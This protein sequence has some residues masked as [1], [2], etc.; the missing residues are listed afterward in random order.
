MKH[1]LSDG[2]AP[3]DVPTLSTV[4]MILVNPMLN[5]NGKQLCLVAKRISWISK[6]DW[7]LL[8][9]FQP[10]PSRSQR[11][12]THT[13]ILLHPHKP[14]V[15]YMASPTA[16]SRDWYYWNNSDSLM[17]EHFAWKCFQ[18]LQ[19]WGQ[20]EQA[21]SPF[22]SCSNTGPN[23]SL[24]PLCKPV[25][26]QFC[27]PDGT[28]FLHLEYQHLEDTKAI[29]GSKSLMTH[30]WKPS[31][32]RT[33]QSATWLLPA[34]E[35]PTSLNPWNCLG[36]VTNITLTQGQACLS[37]YA[38]FLAPTELLCMLLAAKPHSQSQTNWTPWTWMTQ[39]WTQT[40]PQTSTS[41][42]PLLIFSTTTTHGSPLS[43]S[44]PF[45]PQFH[46][47]KAKP[48]PFRRF[49]WKEDACLDTNNSSSYKNNQFWLTPNTIGESETLV[50]ILVA[51][52]EY[53]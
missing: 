6:S 23:I 49:R 21:C 42:L 32:M 19:Q 10:L 12:C 50:W 18:Q 36:N 5:L 20:R 22:P 44:L 3:M 43:F 2:L 47:W 53:S 39:Q 28:C 16:P 25:N 40:T 13:S 34:N 4:W 26:D 1:I 29:L 27:G 51:V 15:S 17:F 41:Q 31:M 48:L 30:V 24:I 14:L 37:L 52:Y 7:T 33:T 46:A 38:L 9:R 35:S 45:C 8:A 11:I